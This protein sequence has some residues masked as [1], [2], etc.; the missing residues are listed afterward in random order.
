MKR[1]RK[2][3]EEFPEE[4]SGLDH[5]FFLTA[6]PVGKPHPAVFAIAALIDEDEEEKS[7]QRKKRRCTHYEG[8]HS[9]VPVQDNLQES[10]YKSK[11]SQP[12]SEQNH[13]DEKLVKA[14]PIEPKKG[15][16]EKTSFGM[17]QVHFSLWTG[18]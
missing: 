13:L 11:E 7:E 14:T 1:T 12:R 2:D 10:Q 9:G 6:P 15:E 17:T 5:P 3:S 18:K 4:P 16:K 8:Y